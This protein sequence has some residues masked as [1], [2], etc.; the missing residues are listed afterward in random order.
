MYVR[1]A[2]FEGGEAEAIDRMLDGIRSQMAEGRQRME[3]GDVPADM[4]EGAR[5]VKRVTIAVDRD[6]G[7]VASLT[8]ADTESDIQ[9]VDAW[10]NEMSPD[11]GGGQ[12]ASVEIY[13]VGIDDQMGT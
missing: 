4:P 10:L 6:A 2:R 8:F 13:E 3:S 11:P 12:R 7:R 1:I 9:K 5:L